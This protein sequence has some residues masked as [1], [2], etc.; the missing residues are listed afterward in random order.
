VTIAALREQTQRSS[1]YAVA[2]I[3][4]FIPTILVLVTLAWVIV[5]RK[6]APPPKRSAP[7]DESLRPL[8]RAP[9]PAAARDFGRDYEGKRQ[10]S[11]VLVPGR[12]RCSH[13]VLD[14]K[15]DDKEHAHAEQDVGYDVTRLLSHSLSLMVAAQDRVGLAGNAS[16][17]SRWVRVSARCEAASHP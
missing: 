17:K 14:D 9:T 11:H 4:G 1:R 16:I 13:E 3:N 8:H 2:I 12:T 15:R 6:E 10:P 7:P 5:H